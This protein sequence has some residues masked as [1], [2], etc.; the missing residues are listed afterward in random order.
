MCP[1]VPDLAGVS[2]L[3]AELFAAATAV[4]VASIQSLASQAK[5][6]ALLPQR[7]GVLGI[8]LAEQL[9]ISA[10]P[11]ISSSSGGK[12]ARR[13]PSAPGSAYGSGWRGLAPRLP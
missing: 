4:Y 13:T 6:R 11:E 3:P 10:L 9:A 8:Q 2:F 5:A 1:I 12:A 7:V